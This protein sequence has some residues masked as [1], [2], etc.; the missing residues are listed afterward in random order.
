MNTSVPTRQRKHF[1]CLSIAGLLMATAAT[2]QI[3]RKQAAL[4]PQATTN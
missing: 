2:A 1:A 4:M 3:T